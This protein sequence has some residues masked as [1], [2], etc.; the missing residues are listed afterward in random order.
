MSKTF[1]VVNGIPSW[2]DDDGVT[3]PI[4][5]GGQD[6]GYWDDFLAGMFGKKPEEEE[7][8]APDTIEKLIGREVVGPYGEHYT[9]QWAP[10]VRPER[11]EMMLKD[12]PLTSLLML[13][14]GNRT[15]P[16]RSGRYV[17]VLTAGLFDVSD[18]G[19][20][21]SGRTLTQSERDAL[22][23][24]LVGPS[25]STY[26]PPEW[27]PGELELEQQEQRRRDQ[28][29]QVDR[30]RLQADIAATEQRLEEIRMQEAAAD[31][32]QRLQ[33]Q[34]EREMLEMRL[35]NSRRELVYS[36]GM[37]ERGTL[38]QEKAET[39]RELMKLDPDFSRQAAILGG[40]VQRGTT[41]QQTVVGQAQAFMNQPLPEV[42]MDMSVSQLES[43]LAQMQKQG[44][45][46]PTFGGWGMARGG[47]IE[48]EQ[49][50]GAFSMKPKMSY[51]VGEGKHGQGIGAG[52]A[53]ILTIG[54]GKVEVTPFGGGA[55][56]GME[57][58]V[59]ST[60][61]PLYTDF[62]DIFSKV[63]RAASTVGGVYSPYRGN[64]PFSL[65]GLSGL[66][67]MGYQP[68]L[69]RFTDR[70][71]VYY[72]DPVTGG[73]GH[74]T[75]R[76]IFEQSG[77]DWKDVVNIEASARPM[78]GPSPDIT[79][80]FAPG[81]IGQERGAFGSLG[82]VLMEASTGAI[83]PPVHKVARQLAQWR[84][85]GD[86]RYDMALIAYR[87]ALDPVT[88]LPTGGLSPEAVNSIVS[89]ATPTAGPFGG[90]R[91]GFTGGWM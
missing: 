87:G 37:Q 51:L 79:K 1:I 32:R 34:A 29:L 65:H 71:E 78:F 4:M 13:K 66:R 19:I 45:T 48:M 36:M 73:Y 7:E 18:Q 31:E 22:G 16:F 23:L 41:P 80:P 24:G 68:S 20:V 50:D 55:A 67:E 81:Q 40:G 15:T 70:P 42:S 43:A 38:I 3:L 27:R 90:R 88:G 83:L 28:E 72:R 56:T 33:L 77:F 62:S 57:M 89:A 26:H 61:S 63:P 85:A 64:Q 74:I 6:D 9:V 60:L 86:P 76:D 14:S 91:I 39:G 35:E 75:S 84:A 8:E 69:I 10:G 21:F 12:V 82:T 17:D 52:T 11:V 47:V 58:N 49:K 59:L 2:R 5:A 30:D 53:E 25:G 54:D 44:M 46:Q